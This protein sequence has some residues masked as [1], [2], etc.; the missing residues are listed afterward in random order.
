MELNKPDNK[1]V[2]TTRKI[3]DSTTEITH[4]NFGSLPVEVKLDILGVCRPKT[5]Y[6]LARTNKELNALSKDEILWK[7]KLRMEHFR[8]EKRG[9][10]AKT[11][12]H[13]SL[14]LHELIKVTF[15]Y[16]ENLSKIRISSALSEDNILDEASYIF[17][18]DTWVRKT[19][20]INSYKEEDGNFIDSTVQ[21]NLNKFT[22]DDRSSLFELMDR[23]RMYKGNHF[24]KEEYRRLS[25]E[26]HSEKVGMKYSKFL[27]KAFDKMILND[28]DFE[29]YDS[30][31]RLCIMYYTIKS[32]CIPRKIKVGHIF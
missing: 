15:D 16:G 9:T 6:T 18:R 13:N 17:E 7:R 32:M 25:E 3:C 28:N 19:P 27:L 11:Y 24:S 5:L 10:W 21:V 30:H 1:L 23:T 20:A 4:T 8:A 31:E 26:F 29:Y 22:D 2:T 14:I 12:E